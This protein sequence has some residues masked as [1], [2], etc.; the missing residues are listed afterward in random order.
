MDSKRVLCILL[1][2]SFVVAVIEL[3]SVQA[4][5]QYSLDLQRITWS[6]STLR[7]LVTPPNN[8]YWW[9]PSYLNATLRAISQWNHAI[10]DFGSNY[11]QFE[12]LTKV[13]LISTLGTTSDSDFDVYISW[14]ETPPSAA[15]EIGYTSTLY[16]VPS[17]MIVNSTIALSAKTTQG[18]VLSEVDMQNIALH[19]LGHSLGLGHC[20]YGEDI[21]YPRYTLNP[22]FQNVQ[23][24]STLDLFGVSTVFQWVS[25]SASPQYV[26]QQA[27]V[28]LP[29]SITYEYLPIAY[30]DVPPAAPSA[31]IWQQLLTQS[32]SMLNYLLRLI[33]RPEIL[34]LI[35][36]VLS[37]MV[38]VF[39]LMLPS[40]PKDTQDQTAPPQ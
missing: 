15:D 18:Y 32:L 27:S 21:M 28:A 36:A 22:L 9:N 29:S 26:P 30:E 5:T 40:K 34:I 16:T 2:L 6:H 3:D 1:V 25:N 8:E 35:I 13:R 11:T 14:T 37:M 39:I 4:Q 24:L 12:Y 31:S 17:R 20:S 38:A 23:A 7:V 33:T 10:T 19:E